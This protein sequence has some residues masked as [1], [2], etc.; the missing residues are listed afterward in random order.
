MIDAWNALAAEYRAVAPTPELKA[1]FDVEL[2]HALGM[3]SHDH[4]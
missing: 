2:Q 1:R 4:M 3:V